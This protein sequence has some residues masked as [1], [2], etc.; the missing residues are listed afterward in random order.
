MLTYAETL[1]NIAEFDDQIEFVCGDAADP[2][3]IEGDQAFQSAFQRTNITVTKVLLE[4][5]TRHRI[6]RF[7]HIFN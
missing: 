3:A 1:A 6:E 5:S 7:V 2:D 4:T